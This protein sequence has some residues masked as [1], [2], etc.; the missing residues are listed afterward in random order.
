MAIEITTIIGALAAVASTTSFVP[1]AVKIIRTRDTDSISTG[2]YSVTVAGFILWTS[3]GVLLG[4]WPLYVSNGLS[5][6]LSAFILTMK[7]LPPSSKE[8][9][10][11]AVE[12]VVGAK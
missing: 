6:L 3:Y 1:Q 2:M 5:L 10:A 9:V 7:L 11:A 8:K 4:A 12:P